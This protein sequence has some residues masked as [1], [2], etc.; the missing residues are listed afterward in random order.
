MARVILCILFVDALLWCY[1]LYRL[2]FG[3]GREYGVRSLLYGEFL[4]LWA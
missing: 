1:R 2:V 3:V 4:G